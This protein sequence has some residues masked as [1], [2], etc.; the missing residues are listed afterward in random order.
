[1]QELERMRYVAANY[2]TLQ[3][4]RFAPLGIF[5]LVW[6]AVVGGWVQVPASVR[7]FLSNWGAGVAFV[8]Y[9]FIQL[10][11]ER[12]FGRAGV[13]C[14]PD[15]VSWPRFIA[16]TVTVLAILIGLLLL[17]MNLQLPVRLFG[18][19]LAVMLFSYFWPKR[20]FAMHYLAIALFAAV[21]SLLPLLR[22]EWLDT[23]FGPAVTFFFLTGMVFL[24]GGL[25]DHLLLV[26][27]FKPLPKEETNGAV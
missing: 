14:K 4:L 5:F 1:M 12:T 22:L 9:P 13:E 19:T 15:K 3:G 20:Q 2:Y 27:T 11:Y 24:I 23:T 10:Y 17:E 18:L 8:F 26:R 6:A 16:G 7:D 25:F 21:L